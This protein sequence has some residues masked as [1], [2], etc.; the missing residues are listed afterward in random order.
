M[1]FASWFTWLEGVTPQ[2]SDRMCGLPPTI[3]STGW[4]NA[5]FGHFGGQNTEATPY[6][7]ITAFRRCT[8]TYGLPNSVFGNVSQ[9]THRQ[10]LLEVGPFMVELFTAVGFANGPRT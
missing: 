4:Q 7:P 3:V 10:A 9:D 5:K 2:A 8:G 1:L 6:P